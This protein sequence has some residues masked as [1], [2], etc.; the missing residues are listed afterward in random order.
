MVNHRY[1][2]GLI[3]KNGAGKSTVA[4]YLMSRHFQMVSL[5]SVVRAYAVEHQLSQDRASLIQTAN[6]LKMT[7]GMDYFARCCV[8]HVSE[9]YAKYVVFDSIRHLKEMAYLKSFHVE[10]W[11]IDAPIELRYQRVQLRQDDT[12]FVDFETFKKQEEF[13]SSGQSVGQ[14][15]NEV[16]NACDF[17]IQNTGEK[18]ALHHCIDAKLK[19]HASALID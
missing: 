1:W 17:F 14:S 5:S 9:N 10:F 15:L 11:G 8:D 6:A 3:G 19:Q 13:E 2:I 12:D 7:Y 18:Q 16:F 4:R